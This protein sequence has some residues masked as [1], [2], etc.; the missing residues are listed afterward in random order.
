MFNARLNFKQQ[1]VHMG[2]KESVVGVTRLMPNVGGSKQKRRALITS[3][4]AS[5][6]TY[7][8]SVWA[9]TLKF[10]ES[11]RR[12]LPIYRRSALKVTSAFRTVA[13]G[14]RYEGQVDI[15]PHPTSEQMAKPK[16]WQCQLLSDANALRIPMLQCKHEQYLE[17]PNCPGIIE[18]AE[19]VFFACPCFNL[20]RNTQETKMKEKFDQRL[21]EMMFLSKAAWDATCTFATMVLQDF[22]RTE[23]QRTKYKRN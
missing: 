10:Q 9:D 15:P 5:V 1:T 7:G 20:Q 17:Y 12:I 18:D 22:R 19:H 23:R 8:I 21:V 6:L 13:L 2:T 14:C 3:M 4:L 11:C 16:T